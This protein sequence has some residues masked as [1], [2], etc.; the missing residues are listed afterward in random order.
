MGPPLGPGGE[1]IAWP[2]QVAPRVRKASSTRKIKPQTSNHK[3]CRAGC[4]PPVARHAPQPHPRQGHRRRNTPG[5]ALVI[6]TAGHQG[7]L[8]GHAGG[9][10]SQILAGGQWTIWHGTTTEGAFPPHVDWR[11][12]PTQAYYTAADPWPLAVL[13]H[14]ISAPSKRQEPG[15]ANPPHTGL[16][17]RQGG[18]STGRIVTRQARAFAL[19]IHNVVIVA[20]SS[21]FVHIHYIIPCTFRFRNDTMMP[22]ACAC[23]MVQRPQQIFFADYGLAAALLSSR[24][25]R[26]MATA[27]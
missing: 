18:A 13:L 8:H 6:Q 11:Q 24:L 22:C 2:D 4:A 5:E 27:A 10:R 1:D 19:W 16:E 20:Y 3:G 15:W 12:E 14:T 26:A 9:Y 25:A 21:L 23:F 7:I 17:A